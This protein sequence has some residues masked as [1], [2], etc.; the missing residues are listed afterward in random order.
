[1]G[2]FQNQLLYGPNQHACVSFLSAA[3]TKACPEDEAH[4]SE[5]INP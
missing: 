4:S 5:H 2:L 3:F 1:M